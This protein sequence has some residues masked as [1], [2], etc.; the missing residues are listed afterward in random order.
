MNRRGFLSKLVSGVVV[1][2][3]LCRIEPPKPIEIKHVGVLFSANRFGKTYMMTNE[4][5][6]AKRVKR[7]V[8]YSYPTGA[9]PLTGLFK[10]LPDDE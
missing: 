10:L 7:T 8:F 1:A 6:L 4:L 5:F 2:A 9:A 3:V